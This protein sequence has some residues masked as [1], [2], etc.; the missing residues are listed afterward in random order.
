MVL[1]NLVQLKPVSLSTSL[2]WSFKYRKHS[3]SRQNGPRYING[4]DDM[5][6]K[7]L[8]K[9]DQF[10]NPYHFNLN[11]IQNLDIFWFCLVLELK[12]DGCQISS[13]IQKLDMYSDVTGPVL[14]TC[15]ENWP[16]ENRTPIQKSQLIKKYNFV[17][18]KLDFY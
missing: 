12:Q 16:F 7:K 17:P 9:I 18:Q 14:K 15:L 10:S 8:D 2:Q 6:W 5:T 3:I 4:D 11:T 13:T 1:T